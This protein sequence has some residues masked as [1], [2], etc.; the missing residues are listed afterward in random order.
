MLLLRHRNR[1]VV[2]LHKVGMLPGN[3]TSGLIVG[4]LLLFGDLLHQFGKLLRRIARKRLPV[5]SKLLE[6]IALGNPLLSRLENLLKLLSKLG[7]K[8]LLRLVKHLGDFINLGDARIPLGT[9]AD[10]SLHSGLALRLGDLLRL[11]RLTLK[12]LKALANRLGQI[13]LVDLLGLLPLSLLR[14]FLTLL[15]KFFQLLLLLV[16][17]RFNSRF[18]FLR[19]TFQDSVKSLLLLTHRLFSLPIRFVK[20]QV[21]RNNIPRRPQQRAVMSIGR[22]NRLRHRLTPFLGPFDNK[23]PPFVRGAINSRDSFHL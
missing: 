4:N 3:L 6:K 10:L 12:L 17:S 19:H 13:S 20:P 2:S 11:L 5:A 14:K 16:K 22:F 21:L 8:L 15:L 18:D 7:R 9:L 1:T 23:K